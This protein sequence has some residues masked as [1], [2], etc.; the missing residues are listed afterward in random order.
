VGVSRFFRGP[1]LTVDFTQTV[2][3]QDVLSVSH[4]ED[5]ALASKMCG[6]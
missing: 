2:D 5:A 1:N 4:R 6:G 3:D